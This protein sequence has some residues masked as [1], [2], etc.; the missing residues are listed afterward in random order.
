M[1]R[2]APD[3]VQEHRITFG[4]YERAFVTEIKNDVEKGVKIATISAI[5]I[6]ATVAVGAVG[7]LGL[8]GYFI[9]RGMD[10][11]A[12]GSNLT[13]P[14]GEEGFPMHFK[15]LVD[16]DWYASVVA[17]TTDTYVDKKDR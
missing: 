5:A 8:L 12:F 11:W 14:F 7:G 9:Y 2:R 16:P 13:N 4:N 1:P 3:Q 10:G 15:R 17:G 6:P